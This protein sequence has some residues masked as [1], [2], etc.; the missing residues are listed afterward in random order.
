[1]SGPMVLATKLAP[2]LRRGLHRRRLVQLLD[3]AARHRLTLLVA[4]AG[5]GKTSLLADWHTTGRRE[6]VGWLALDPED[7]DRAGSGPT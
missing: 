2:P 4:P 7:S 1:M 3:G 6:R 5:W